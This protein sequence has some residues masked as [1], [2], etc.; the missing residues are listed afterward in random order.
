[1]PATSALTARSLSTPRLSASSSIPISKKRLMSESGRGEIRGRPNLIV[2][3]SFRRSKNLRDPYYHP[4][5]SA[6]SAESAD[7]TTILVRN[8]KFL[9]ID[10]EVS[11]KLVSNLS[12]TSP[13]LETALLAPTGS[14]KDDW[15]VNTGCTTHS[16]ADQ[17]QF[18]NFQEG[19]FG[20]CSGARGRVKFEGIADVPISIP[21]PNGQPAIL[22]LKNVKYY[23]SMGLYNLISVSQL[24][25]TK[26]FKLV[27]EENAIS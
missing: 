13:P 16:F 14:L 2:R 10:S 3:G 15:F 5:S 22:T 11:D 19:N 9:A 12:M 8:F 20:S 1:V 27:L 21:R 6:S 26:K 4:N 25:K 18:I 17:S 24:F 7:T 23:P